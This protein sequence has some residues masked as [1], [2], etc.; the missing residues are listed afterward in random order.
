[1]EL[2]VTIRTGT[3]QLIDSTSSNCVRLNRRVLQSDCGSSITNR[4]THGQGARNAKLP[5]S[6]MDRLSMIRVLSSLS[7]L[8]CQK[9]FKVVKLHER[10]VKKTVQ[11]LTSCGSRA[12]CVRED[13][14]SDTRVDGAKSQCSVHPSE[15]TRMYRTPYRQVIH[16]CEPCLRREGLPLQ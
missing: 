9:S 14:W 16:R 11:N 8:H 12:L 6:V 1:M 5:V 13:L 15:G 3:R 4:K 10:R 7:L 2:C